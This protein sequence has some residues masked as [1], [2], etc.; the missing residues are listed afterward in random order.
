MYSQNVSVSLIVSSCLFL[1]E[2]TLV[3]VGDLDGLDS[4]SGGSN[5]KENFVSNFSKSC[6]NLNSLARRTHEFKCVLNVEKRPVYIYLSMES[7]DSGT[8]LI[9]RIRQN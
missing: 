1:L 2:I 8:S 9:F 4:G 3:G 7:N 6:S 5:K